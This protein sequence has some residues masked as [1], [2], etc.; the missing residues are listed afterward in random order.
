MRDLTHKHIRVPHGRGIEHEVM[1][2]HLWG[3]FSWARRDDFFVVGH[4]SVPTSTLWQPTTQCLQLSNAQELS[5]L[6]WK[7]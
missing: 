4:R 1:R 3:C 6:P 7:L 5:L 2:C